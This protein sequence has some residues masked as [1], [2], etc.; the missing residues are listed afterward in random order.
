M[1]STCVSQLGR[2]TFRAR[3]KS[4]VLATAAL[5]ILGGSALAADLPSRKGP[6]LAPVYVPP[7]FTWTG[8][9]VG[10]NAGGGWT[11]NNNTSNNGFPFV[12]AVP[13][14]GAFIPFASSGSS[15][16]SGFLG[17]V[18][19]GYNYQ[20]GYGSGFVIGAE[21]DIDWANINRNKNNGVVFGSFTL[22]QFPGT[23]FTPSNIATSSHSN[24]NQYIGTVRLRAGYAWDR[25][26]V[27]ATGGLAYGGV[28]NNNNVGSA[29]TATT[30]SC[31]VCVVPLTGGA[32]NVTGVPVTTVI[33]SSLG[34]RSSSTKTGWTVGGGVEYAFTPNWTVKGEYLYENFGHVN[35]APG[36]VLPGVATAFNN[37]NR[38]I[39][40]NVVRVGLNYKFW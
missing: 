8:F 26:L 14:G 2:K 35:S 37:S 16:R 30:L 40:V 1:Y 27:Y 11:N 28:N 10:V 20:F 38:S 15:N 39:N 21:T 24:N 32:T 17:G 4:A 19:A 13:V 25:I 29:L 3:L 36:L 33:G 34:S 7:A 9:Y 23:V 6:P 12:G 31:G 5:G 18:Q 22:P